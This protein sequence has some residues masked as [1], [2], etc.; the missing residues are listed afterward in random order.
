MNVRAPI[1]FAAAVSFGLS[2]T[3][4]RAWPQTANCAPHDAVVAR[5]QADYSETRVAMGLTVNGMMMETFA[6]A[7]GGTWTIAVTDVA[8]M[9]CLVAA[10]TSFDFTQDK[11]GV[12]G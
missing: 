11:P 1:L 6:S 2:L 3:A 12:D 5:L 7:D 10:G 8:G 4:G 9:T